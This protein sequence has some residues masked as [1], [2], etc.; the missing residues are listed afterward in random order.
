MWAILLR[1]HSHFHTDLDT[2]LDQIRSKDNL[3]YFDSLL[4]QKRVSSLSSVLSVSLRRF[5]II[6]LAPVAKD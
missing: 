5:A 2:R 3:Q 6:T 4:I 1:D